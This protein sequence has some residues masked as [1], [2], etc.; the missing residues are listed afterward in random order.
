[1]STNFEETPGMHIDPY[2]RLWIIASIVMLVV[3]AGAVTVAG[4]FMGIQLPSPEAKVDP[5][6]VT[7]P[8]GPFGDENVG[9]YEIAPGEYEAYLRGQTWAWAP[10]EI[11]VPAGSRVTFYITS[12]DVIHGYKVID[13]NIN[14]MVL[15]GQISKVS[16]S[17]DEPGEYQII[18]NEYCGTGHAIM[19][20]KVIVTEP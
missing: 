13:T 18:C 15:P 19:A 8:D 10:R 7:A 17:F 20:G 4:F 11:T 16:M 6:V 2:E 5:A 12:R 3:F 1:M 14:I 9:L